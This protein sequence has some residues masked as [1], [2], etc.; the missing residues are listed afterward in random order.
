[1]V[2]GEKAWLAQKPLGVNS[3]HQSV[4]ATNKQ[5]MQV[6]LKI[7]NNFPNIGRQDIAIPW[8]AKFTFTIGINSSDPNATI[9]Q[10]IDRNFLWWK[11][12]S[13]L[14]QSSPPA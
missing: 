5:I 2:L 13:S 3:I 12:R 4:A 9:E 11:R 8:T 14:S 6:L 1:M 7:I 10:T